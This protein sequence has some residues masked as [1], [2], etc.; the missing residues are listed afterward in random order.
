M[1]F[2]V[3]IF[4]SF[5][6]PPFPSFSVTMPSYGTEFRNFFLQSESF[7]F[8]TLGAQMVIV[9]SALD[10]LR[11]ALVKKWVAMIKWSFLQ[12]AG[13]S[14]PLSVCLS[15]WLSVSLSLSVCPFLHL[16]ANPCLSSISYLPHMPFAHNTVFLLLRSIFAEPIIEMK[17]SETRDH[18]IYYKSITSSVSSV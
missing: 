6:S 1:N 4:I 8:K 12:G 2:S 13:L 16:S 15:A 5:F 18:N 14:V 3:D 10:G 9:P 17:V 7:E 11:Q